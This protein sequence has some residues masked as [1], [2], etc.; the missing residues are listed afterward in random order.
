M[1]I[2]HG[3]HDDG[4]FNTSVWWK[5]KEEE[6]LPDSVVESFRLHVPKGHAF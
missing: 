1:G 2:P 4:L 6:G 3:G 5:G